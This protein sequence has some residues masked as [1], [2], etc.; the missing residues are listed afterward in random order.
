MVL[1]SFEHMCQISIQKKS[2]TCLL[3]I[4]LFSHVTAVLSDDLLYVIWRDI[5]LPDAVR[6]ASQYS[7]KTIRLAQNVHGTISLASSGPLGSS[8]FF[9]LFENSLH[10]RGLV[11]MRDGG[12]IYQVRAVEPGAGG[13]A[14]SPSASVEAGPPHVPQI[15]YVGAVFASERRA[16]A[17]VA[18]IRAMGGEAEVRAPGDPADTGFSVVL[19]CRDS[20]EGYQSMISAVERAGL[21]NLISM[22]SL[23]AAFPVQET[24]SFA[25]SPPPSQP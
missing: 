4:L 24:P 13:S 23:P 17:I 22:P 18:R 25:D 19:L 7:G 12:N 2:I 3:A 10:E 16:Q 21:S 20:A 1:H 5:G 11:L 14:Q 15:E 6:L 9:S 8:Q